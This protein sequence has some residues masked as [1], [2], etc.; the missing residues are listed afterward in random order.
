M[1][2]NDL[3]TI[4]ALIANINILAENVHKN[5]RIRVEGIDSTIVVTPEVIQLQRNAW[6][7]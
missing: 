5:I 1:I 2:Y 6:T 4:H 7:H 3:S